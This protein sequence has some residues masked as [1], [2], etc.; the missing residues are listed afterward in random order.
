[1][2]SIFITFFVYMYNLYRID[3][4]IFADD[5]FHKTIDILEELLDNN[6]NY[7]EYTDK[8]KL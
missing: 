7:V 2:Y 8:M 1:M 5:P 3:K 6:N 4:I